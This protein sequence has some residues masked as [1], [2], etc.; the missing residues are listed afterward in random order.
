M[1]RVDLLF[2]PAHSNRHNKGI[3]KMEIV[4]LFVDK[5]FNIQG[6]VNPWVVVF[7]FVGILAY[8]LLHRYILSKTY[9]INEV[10]L[11]IGS[12]KVKIK[13]NHEDLQ[14]AYKLFVELNTRKIGL[15]IDVEHDVIEE[16]YNS[17]H[18]FFQ[19]TRDLIKGIPAS[20][21]RNSESTRN[22]VR[23]ATEVLNLGVRPHLTQWQARFR[24][25]YERESNET[26]N[27]GKSPQEIQKRFPYYQQLV[28]D[29]LRVNKCLI[30]YKDK[31]NQMV[32]NK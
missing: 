27:H 11:G 21:I 29:L 32:M 17:W 12:A 15:P 8:L 14:I 10:E 9:D 1:R 31:L 16:V 19:I 28:D 30:K 7:M 13:P 23:I 25:W 20:K 26:S 2:L 22:L 5:D 3:I 24:R 18:D 4:R 6:V